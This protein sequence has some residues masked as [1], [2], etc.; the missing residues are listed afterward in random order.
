MPN[1]CQGDNED[2]HHWNECDGILECSSQG[3]HLPRLQC[4]PLQRLQYQ[5]RTK[6]HI[7]Y[8]Q[9]RPL[10]VKREPILRL[11]PNISQPH[12][13]R[14][15]IEL[16]PINVI[17]DAQPSLKIHELI[18]HHCQ[19]VSIQ[20]FFQVHLTVE[21]IYLGFEQSEFGNVESILEGDVA[22]GGR[23]TKL[24]FQ[25]GVDSFELV[26]EGL[27]GYLGLFGFEVGGGFADLGAEGGI[28]GGKVHVRHGLS[29]S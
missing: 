10:N 2:D 7:I 25:V 1:G 27:E 28:D 23:V 29:R 15:S 18:R 4:I 17:I 14:L 21:V 20:N 6:H 16:Q 8:E 12:P 3:P 19:N 11:D 22:L 9:P 5:T 26:V 24:A 13:Y